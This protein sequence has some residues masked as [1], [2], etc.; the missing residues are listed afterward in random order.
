MRPVYPL[1]PKR[2]VPER[3]RL[4]DYAKDGIPRS[5]RAFT[6]R[7]NITILNAK[8]QGAMRK[9]CRMAREVLD[10]AAQAIKPGI[11]TDE[12][13]EIVHNACLE[14]DVSLP[15]SCCALIVYR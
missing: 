15:K 12:I 6:G 1:S 3:I 10:I 11:T 9:V 13:D 5:E 14:R 2:I 7:H 4:P 8:E